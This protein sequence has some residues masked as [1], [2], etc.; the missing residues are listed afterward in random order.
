MVRRNDLC[1]L[2]PHRNLSDIPV[3]RHA[4]ES[5]DTV[6]VFLRRTLVRFDGTRRGRKLATRVLL[7]VG[8]IRLGHSTL[9]SDKRN[10]A[11]TGDNTIDTRMHITTI[12]YS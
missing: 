8:W 1:F 5:D 11:V 9:S 10:V 4:S 12:H 6:D 7:Q 2:F 3:G